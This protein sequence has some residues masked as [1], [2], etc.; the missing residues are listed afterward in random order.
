MVDKRRVARGVVRWGMCSGAVMTSEQDAIPVSD[1]RQIRRLVN[2]A[3]EGGEEDCYSGKRRWPRFMAGMRLEITTDPDDH[4]AA[5]PAL[6]HNVSRG[7]VAFWSKRGLR[8]RDSVFVREFGDDGAHCWLPAQVQHC[9]VGL[10][11]YLI[12]VA[13]GSTSLPGLP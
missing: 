12:G 6:M 7:G 4:S 10:R 13:F 1:E 3:K 9:T 2:A 5:W 8:A 11:G